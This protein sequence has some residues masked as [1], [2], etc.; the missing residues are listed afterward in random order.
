MKTVSSAS[1]PYNL[2]GY[3]FGACVAFE[4]A[5]QLQ[6]LGE[7]RALVLLDGSHSYVASH[8]A[9]YKAKIASGQSDEKKE[10]LLAFATQFSPVDYLKV[11]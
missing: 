5:L 10:A 7:L 2:V 8:T 11:Y 4:M 6:K 1:P 3:S 9:K